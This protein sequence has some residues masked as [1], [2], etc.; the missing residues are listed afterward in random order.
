MRVLDLFSGIG[1]FSLGLERAGMQTVAFCEIDPFCRKVLSKHWPDVRC[2][3]DVTTM[4]FSDG[5][6][7]VVCGGFP[8][9]DIS[10]AGIGKG[11]AGLRSGLFRELVRAIRVVRPKYAILENVAALLGRG[12]GTVLGDLATEGY[13]AEWDCVQASFVGSPCSR[14]RLWIVAQPYGSRFEGFISFFG[15]FSRTNSALAE[16]SD[17]FTDGW[18]ALDG[19]YS[20]LRE[21]DGVSITMDRNRIRSI[22]NAVVPQIPEMIGRAI[23][24]SMENS[25][26]MHAGRIP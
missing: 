25:Q 7:D 12:M 1:G 4:D 2:R 20:C 18:R 11:L 22:G 19:D 6:A 17:A 13:D 5:D 10:I 24:A 26:P 15:A 23:I 14:D 3:D 21:R 16:F 9:Q 8:C